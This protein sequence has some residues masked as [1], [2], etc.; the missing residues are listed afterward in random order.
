MRKSIISEETS[1]SPTAWLDLES[2]SSVEL[3]S[4]DQAH[5]IENAFRAREVSG[6]RAQNAGKQKI[7]L[8]FDE[9][10]NVRHIHLV[11]QE[12]EHQRTQ[13]FLLRWSTGGDAPYREVHRQQYNFNPPVN[14]REVED[15]KVELN[16]LMR[17]ELSIIP[18]ISGGEARASL[19]K[20]LLA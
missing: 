3:T 10:C 9:P 20:M 18:D 8:L 7:C 5:P 16:G 14:T 12:Q 1:I 6:W 2:L 4:E 15:Y 11:F 19:E 13:E 17:L